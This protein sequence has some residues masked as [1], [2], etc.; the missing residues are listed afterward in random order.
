MIRRSALCLLAVLVTGT[1]VPGD[2][3]AQYGGGAGGGYYGGGGYGGGGGYHA[4]G[5]PR[6]ERHGQRS[7]SQKSN[8]PQCYTKR[9]KGQNG[10]WR[11]RRV[12]E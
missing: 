3:A 2:A 11:S 10:Q 6:R 9:T 8:G 5:P 12:C 7:G 4:D 1:L